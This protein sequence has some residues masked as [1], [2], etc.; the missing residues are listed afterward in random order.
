MELQRSAGVRIGRFLGAVVGVLC[1]A[2][3]GCPAVVITPPDGDGDGDGD[4]VVVDGNR[5]ASLTSPLGKTSGEPNDDF[6]EPVVAVFDDDGVARLQG[7]VTRVGDVDVYVLGS[8]QAGDRL[9]VE[10]YAFG[11]FLDVTVV[12]YD[13][14][15]RIVMNNDDRDDRDSL[16]ALVDFTVRHG[17]A[18]YYLAVSNSPLGAPTRLA[19][20]YRVDLLLEPGGDVP[21]PVSQTM[22]LDFDGA[23]VTSPALLSLLQVDSLTLASFDAA[24][25][26]ATYEG[27]TQTLKDGI[28]EVFEQNYERFGVTV[29]TTDDPPVAAGT[30]T[31]IIY[32]GGFDRSVFGIAEDVDVLNMNRCD[33]A[34]IFAETFSPAVF[35]RTPSAAE[36]GVAIGN[37]A[38][39]EA[40]HLL[41]LN[42]TDDDTDLMDDQ[43]PADAFLFD[44]EFKEAPLS[45][46]ILPLGSQDGVLLL[47]EIVGPSAD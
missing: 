19:G 38:A 7:T 33:D 9:V 6:D 2:L 22:L 28:R 8:L 47:D 23:V 10:A 14:Q 3:A 39:H 35:S 20:E 4:G 1:C 5:D 17:G 27:Q 31:S 21:P 12:I 25:I 13:A 18:R 32:F 29:V 15:E 11:S 24:D 37:V 40:G 41:G 46:D 45:G 36:L 44:Q 16:D 34:L 26:S 43:S 42:H 30:P